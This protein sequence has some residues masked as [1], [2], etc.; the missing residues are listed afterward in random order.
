MLDKG[1]NANKRSQLS[2]E[3]DFE[4]VANEAFPPLV[5]KGKVHSISKKPKKTVIMQAP[6]DNS[7][8][9][10]TGKQNN[11]T[12]LIPISKKVSSI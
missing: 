10:L 11:N 6:I 7:T 4:G 8:T 5:S 9:L 12:N 3:S 1:P 2:D